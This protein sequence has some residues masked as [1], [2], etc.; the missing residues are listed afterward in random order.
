MT[1][2]LRRR[3]RALS[4]QFRGDHGQT[5]GHRARQTFH[6]GSQHVWPF[7]AKKAELVHIEQRAVASREVS[8]AHALERPKK[9]NE[10]WDSSD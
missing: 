10:E 6:S 9:R 5:F 2:R 1:G 3:G 7:F 4:A 8:A